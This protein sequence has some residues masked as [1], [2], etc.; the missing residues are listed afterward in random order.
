LPRE[1]EKARKSRENP[2]M[3]NAIKAALV[4]GALVSASAFGQTLNPNDLVVYITDSNGT[5]Y[6]DD[7][8]IALSSVVNASGGAATLPTAAQLN[9][10]APNLDAFLAQGGTFTWTIAAAGTATNSPGDQ[11]VFTSNNTNIAT[12]Y[13]PV[14]TGI[15]NAINFA[16]VIS[17]DLQ[18]NGTGSG[19][20]TSTHDGYCTGSISATQWKQGFGSS[21]SIVSIAG[22][23]GSMAL[24]SVTSG[25]TSTVVNTGE[26]ITLTST[27]FTVTGA[28]ATP[29]PA[30]A[31][32]LG[33]GLLGL[34]GVGRR[35]QMA[36]A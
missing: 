2:F 33:S 30:A 3:K 1:A 15:N 23:G 7:T 25:A 17:T 19:C 12:K 5:Y 21:S 26:T 31:W 11:I 6:A 35:R 14:D 28:S 18:G 34:I 20:I 36:L 10:N 8:G 24:Y 29:L 9:G 4:G 27:G 32:L 16:S 22:L 13:G